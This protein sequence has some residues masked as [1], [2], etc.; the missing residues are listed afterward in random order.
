MV[1][2][3]VSTPKPAL[4]MFVDIIDSSVYSSIL[5]IT[6]FADKVLSF[7]R[8]FIELGKCYLGGKEIWKG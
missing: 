6:K 5:G 7:Q 3:S 4:L 1:A 8:L 2:Y